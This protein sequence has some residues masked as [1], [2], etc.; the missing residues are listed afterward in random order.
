MVG[1]A[2]PFLRSEQPTTCGLGRTFSQ[3]EAFDLKRSTTI[4]PVCGW[5]EHRPRNE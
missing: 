5:S 4:W 1:W 2:D 3:F